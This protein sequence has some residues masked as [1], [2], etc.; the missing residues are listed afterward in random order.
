MYPVTDL[1]KEKINEDGREFTCNITIEHSQGTLELTDDDL[2]M[3]SLTYTEATQ[4]GDEYTIG[5]TVA[6]D[7]SFTIF[8]KPEYE[9]IQFMVQLYL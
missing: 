5:S 1:Y 3:G 9:D 8:K 2:S 4:S 7:I 6:S